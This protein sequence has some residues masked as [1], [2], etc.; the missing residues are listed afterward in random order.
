MK[1]TKPGS[2]RTVNFEWGVGGRQAEGKV[3]CLE[4]VEGGQNV[5]RGVLKHII[6][7]KFVS[8]K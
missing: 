8:T 2:M 3:I 1:V 5:S 7:T 6:M 4:H